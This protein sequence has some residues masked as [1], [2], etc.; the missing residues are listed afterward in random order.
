MQRR[1]LA[2]K[3]R[4]KLIFQRVEVATFSLQKSHN[5]KNKLTLIVI[6]TQ[7]FWN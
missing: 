1:N 6:C 3:I 2:V 5:L 4:Y 7:K